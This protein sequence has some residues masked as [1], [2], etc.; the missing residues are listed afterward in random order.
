MHNDTVKVANKIISDRDLMCI[1]LEMNNQLENLK[2]I[3][4]L[5]V[6]QN[7]MLDLKSQNWTLKDFNGKFK[8]SINFYDNNR[9]ETEDFGEFMNIFNHRIREIKGIDIYYNYNYSSKRGGENLQFYHPYIHMYIK[10]DKMDISVNLTG[11]K[12][13]DIYQLIKETILNAPEKYDRII[14]K[15]LSIINKV[16]FARG[17]IPSMIV[18]FLLIFVPTIKQLYIATYIGY[19]I[20]A[21]LVGFVMG[22]VFFSRK[23][24]RLY[25]NIA[26][27]KKYAGYD[28]NRHTSIYENDIQ[29]FTETSEIIIGKNTNNIKN[30]DMIVK[31]EKKYGKLI[32][33][34]LLAL[35]ILSIIVV[36]IGKIL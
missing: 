2:R 21:L 6:E 25:A 4:Q 17:I 34:E 20:A 8:A 27:D 18:L 28:Y 9:I 1:F 29:K 14:K 10:E 32:P 5:E 3:Y 22:G 7:K 35:L 26:P 31:M 16:S 11:D 19:P 30:R 36:V 24:E 33:Y 13:N 12:M 15:K 23:I